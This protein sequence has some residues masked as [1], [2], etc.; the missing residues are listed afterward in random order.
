VDVKPCR[1]PCLTNPTRLAADGGS[2]VV[3]SVTTAFA[4]SYRQD[5]VLADLR[6]GLHM[7]VIFDHFWC[8]YASNPHRLVKTNLSPRQPDAVVGTTS[9]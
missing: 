6:H 1:I 4:V 7:Y 5:Y 8:G 2:G 9:W 3:A